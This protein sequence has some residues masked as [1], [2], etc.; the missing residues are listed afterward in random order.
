M[1]S[2]SSQN[3]ASFGSLSIAGRPVGV[4][5]VTSW[6]N[7]TTPKSV[8][9][10]TNAATL[11]AA[12]A[13]TG[14]I[15]TSGITGNATLPLPSAADLV[16]AVPG[17]QVGTVV[18]LDVMNTVAYTISFGTAATGGTQLSGSVPASSSATI[19]FVITNPVVGSEAYVA[20]IV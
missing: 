18:A 14:V 2:H 3:R 12:Q 15:T 6:T 16:A 17:A 5:P 11:T 10:A 19:K 4:S 7:F 13:V 20:Y 9:F 8:A 1:S